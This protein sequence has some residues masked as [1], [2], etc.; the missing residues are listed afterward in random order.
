M[1]PH[2]ANDENEAGSGSEMEV[3]LE[4]TEDDRRIAEEIASAKEWLQGLSV[5][6]IINKDVF[7]AQKV[8]QFK[9]EFKQNKPFPFLSIPNFVESDYL[10]QVLEEVKI[11]DFR[12]KNKD[13]YNFSQSNDLK[14]LGFRRY[15]QWQCW[16]QY[17]WWS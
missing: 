12:E 10:K 15:H 14:T 7:D 9:D 13:L 17:R 3:E 16:C 2:S 6:D 4:F 8:A 1:D 5:N 11:M